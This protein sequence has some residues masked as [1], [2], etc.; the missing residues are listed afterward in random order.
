MKG[1]TG[2]KRKLKLKQLL[3]RNYRRSREGMG[4]GQTYTIFCKRAMFQQ[5][6]QFAEDPK[7]QRMLDQLEQRSYDGDEG[8]AGLTADE[9]LK[10]A[11]M[12]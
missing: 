6:L 11:L 4:V 5:F 9:R 1:L 3:A 7:T 10:Y 8:G 12:K 2:V